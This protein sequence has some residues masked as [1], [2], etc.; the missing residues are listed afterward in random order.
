MNLD[1]P[2][3]SPHGRK[4]K[5]ILKLGCGGSRDY[6]GEYDCDHGYTWSCDYCP[7]VLQRELDFVGPPVPEHLWGRPRGPIIQEFEGFTLK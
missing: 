4:W 1:I 3:T 7:I 2:P 6:W 5:A